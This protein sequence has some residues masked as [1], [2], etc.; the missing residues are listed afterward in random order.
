MDVTGCVQFPLAGAAHFELCYEAFCL[1]LARLQSEMSYYC[2]QPTVGSVG[3]THYA[4]SSLMVFQEDWEDSAREGTVVIL[5]IE[6]RSS[7][8]DTFN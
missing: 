2:T 8:R 4:L 1:S 6:A 3:I 5:N 7:W